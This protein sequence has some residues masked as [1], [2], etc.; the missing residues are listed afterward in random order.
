MPSQTVAGRTPAEVIA[1]LSAVAD[2]ERRLAVHQRLFPDQLN[3]AT[4]ENV[5]LYAQLKEKV[6]DVLPGITEQDIRYPVPIYGT[7]RLREDI[8]AMLRPQFAADLDAKDVFG[9]S[10]VSAALECLAFALKNGGILE[11]GDRVLI[12]AP[13]WQGFKWCFQQRPGLVCVPA[14]LTEKGL[15]NF[16]L[17]LD[18]LKRAYYAEPR[19]PKLLVLTNPHN[20][21]GVN[22]SKDLLEKIYAWALNETEM[23]V[24]SDEMYAHSQITTA[25]QPFVS[26]LSLDAYRTIAQAPERVHVVWG[27]AKDFGLS[28][29]KAG[30]VISRSSVVHDAL[31]GAQGEPYS[32]FSPFDSLKHWVIGNLLETQ[33]SGRSFA[34]ELME[35]YRGILTGAFQSARAALDSNHIPYVFQ[36]G[37]NPAQFF[38]LDLRKYLSP[39][40]PEIPWE[41]GPHF[42]HAG[43]V[44]SGG[45][46]N[47]N[48][49]GNGAKPGDLRLPVVFSEISNAE[50]DLRRY[51]AEKANVLL[52][53]GQTLTCA[54]PG[55]F[56]LCYTAFHEQ[57]IREAIDRIGQALASY[58]S[59]D[60]D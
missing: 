59:D 9:T 33:D 8:A 50:E 11:T 2:P 37:Q 5:L 20:P 52:L 51:I 18:D 56:R 7:D 57:T 1:L 32:W 6:F 53:P 13:F 28:G 48:G 17:T 10:G 43:I 34:A 49:N 23:H 55:Y 14:N 19:R 26:A 24:I 27:F 58:G 25:T 36:E 16:E 21:L 46:G 35:S 40:A 30:V 22:Y 44:H 60:D 39:Q 47:G 42:P 4:A 54:E 31:G 29:F 45:N 38:W 15:Q 12:P 41:R 3:L